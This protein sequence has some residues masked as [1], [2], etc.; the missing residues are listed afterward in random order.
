MLVNGNVFL[1]SV[2]TCSIFVYR[3]HVSFFVLVLQDPGTSLYSLLEY[4]CIS[5][6]FYYVN[7]HVICKQE[8]FYFFQILI[9]FSCLLYCL[10][11]SALFRIIVVRVNR[12]ALFLISKEKHCLSILS[13]LLAYRY[14]VNF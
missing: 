12:F 7:N 4:F 11:F 1:I 2:S 13:I 3:N 14:L 5:L 8:Q 10:Q 9:Y 6:G